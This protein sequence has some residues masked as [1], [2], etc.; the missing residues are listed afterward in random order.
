MSALSLV[1]GLHQNLTWDPK[2]RVWEFRMWNKA[3]EKEWLKVAV[4][5][6]T[7]LDKITER[8]NVSRKK[9]WCFV[10][11]F[12]ELQMLLSPRLQVGPDV[13]KP[14]SMF[15]IPIYNKITF[16]VF[17]A[18]LFIVGHVVSFYSLTS[19]N[20]TSMPFHASVYILLTGKPTLPP[21]QHIHAH[22][23][24]MLLTALSHTY[25][26]TSGNSSSF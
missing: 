7:R 8:I 22:A 5:K 12:L 21:S 9:I 4:F 3:G 23:T 10:L 17:Y 1:R 24:C 2:G 26:Y 16:S 15:F 13:Q 19:A 11:F 25:T 20:K 6:A 18:E 14:L